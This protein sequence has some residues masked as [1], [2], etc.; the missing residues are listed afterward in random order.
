M[1]F[2]KKVSEMLKEAEPNL[3]RRKQLAIS[4]LKE[5][6]REK[7]HNEDAIKKAIESEGKEGI[8]RRVR[9]KR[10]QVREEEGEVVVVY[11]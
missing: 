1:K 5:L 2:L 4:I 11:S 6:E 8:L 3:Y 7:G 9:R 10:K